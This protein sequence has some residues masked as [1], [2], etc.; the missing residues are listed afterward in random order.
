MDEVVKHPEHTPQQELVRGY[1]REAEALIT[2]APSRS[3]AIRIKDEWCTRF[4]KECE[5]ELLV[6]AA[7]AYLDTMIASQW[8]GYA[9]HQTQ[10][11]N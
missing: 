4:R 8:G 1:C 7:S 5:S 10:Q 6:N 9:A 2:I 11:H 3:D